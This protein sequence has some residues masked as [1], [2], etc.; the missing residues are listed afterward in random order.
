M[1]QKA[2]KNLLKLI[3]IISSDAAN[4]FSDADLPREKIITTI[5]THTHINL[6]MYIY[7]LLYLNLY[8]CVCIPY[9]ITRN[10]IN[11][12]KLANGKIKCIMAIQCNMMQLL[13][14][15]DYVYFD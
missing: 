12:Q 6:Y 1:W 3:I 13:I 14:K 11:V 9:R 10:K 5:Y 8:V 15:M 2:A 4:H 7:T